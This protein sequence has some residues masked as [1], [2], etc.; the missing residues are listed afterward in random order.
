MRVIDC[1]ISLTYRDPKDQPPVD[2]RPQGVETM[3][4]RQRRCVD[5][6]ENIFRMENPN[7]I[8]AKYWR[9]NVA[10]EIFQRNFYVN[11]LYVELEN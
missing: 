9:V 3:G 1:R 10:A 11:Q 2:L 6:G 7:N 5:E 8:R 4:S